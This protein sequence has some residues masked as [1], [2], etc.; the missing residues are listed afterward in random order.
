MARTTNEVSQVKKAT[1]RA[2]STLKL[3]E[4]VVSV[5]PALAGLMTETW[6]FPLFSLVDPLACPTAMATVL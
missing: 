3:A 2:A 5:P 4:T 1:L 6:M